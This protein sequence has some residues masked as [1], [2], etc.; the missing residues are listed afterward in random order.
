MR[1]LRV[2]L[3]AATGLAV[4]WC[5]WVMYQRYSARREWETRLH[6]TADP[7]AVAQ[8]NKVYGGSEVKILNF[9]ATAVAE[10]GE[11]TLL[12]YG[13]LNAK[14]VRID[15]P[16]EGVYP[17]AGKCVE[18]GPEKETRY[19]LTAEDAAGHSVSA[20]LTLPVKAESVKKR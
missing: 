6:P 3:L 11:T 18:V 17:T 19:T 10:A 8:F 9:Y 1:A 5:G 4:L 15:P 2:S 7:T 20:S 12:C 14:A 16:V 13:V